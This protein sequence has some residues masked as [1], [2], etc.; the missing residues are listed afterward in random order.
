MK[1]RF[2]RSFF[3]SI[4]FLIS[5]LLI[6]LNPKIQNKSFSYPAFIMFFSLFVICIMNYK[7]K[8]SIDIKIMLGEGV[9]LLFLSIY[10]Y[11]FFVYLLS[12]I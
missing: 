8:E 9:F 11:Y 1:T 7:K 3:S 2:F 12:G 5:G 6:Y 4:G 10:V